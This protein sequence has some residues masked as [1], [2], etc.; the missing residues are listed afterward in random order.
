MIEITRL[1]EPERTQLVYLKL[2]YLLIP[3]KIL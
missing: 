2:V 3:I 1:T